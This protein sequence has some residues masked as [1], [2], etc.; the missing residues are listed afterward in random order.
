MSLYPSAVEVFAANSE[1]DRLAGINP[2]LDNATSIAYAQATEIMRMR[3]RVPTHD[4]EAN[5]WN[6]QC[7]ARV[8]SQII[9]LA[10]RIIRNATPTAGV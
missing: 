3:A 1:K 10:D 7:L 4:L 8:K 6:R 9:E 2:Y 5:R